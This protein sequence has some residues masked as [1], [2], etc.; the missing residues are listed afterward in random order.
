MQFTSII[1]VHCFNI[2]GRWEGFAVVKLLTP[3][4]LLTACS[5]IMVRT[6]IIIILA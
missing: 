2:V 1:I 6:L 3:N 4:K 5:I